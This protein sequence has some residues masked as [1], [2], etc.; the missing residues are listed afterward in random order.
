MRHEVACED[1][2]TGGRLP[3]ELGADVLALRADPAG[4]HVARVAEPAQ[5]LRDLRGMA[6]R[7]GDIAGTHRP[8]E[9]RGDPKPFLE[10][11]H[12]RLG[13]HEDVVGEHVPRADEKAFSAYELHDELV[14]VWPLL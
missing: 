14:V 6:E 10:I 3:R 1:A 5:H 11:A 4:E 8:A 2:V 12:E 13:G 9:G 7:I